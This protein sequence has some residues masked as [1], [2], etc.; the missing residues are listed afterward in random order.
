MTEIHPDHPSHDFQIRSVV[1]LQSIW[2][3]RELY[4][5]WLLVYSLFIFH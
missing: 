1:R 5:F 3:L 4:K 2:D